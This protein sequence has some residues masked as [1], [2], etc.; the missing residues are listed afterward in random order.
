VCTGCAAVFEVSRTLLR[1]WWILFEQDEQRCK[2]VKEG[3]ADSDGP[4]PLDHEAEFDHV[5]KPIYRTFPERH[6]DKNKVDDGDQYEIECVFE[7]EL[8]PF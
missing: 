1:R 3:D 8:S 2:S 5:V 4:S 6:S 7:H